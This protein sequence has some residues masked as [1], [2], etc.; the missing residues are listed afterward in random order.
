[1]KVISTPLW[2]W[3]V[4]LGSR[5]FKIVAHDFC[6]LSSSLNASPGCMFRNACG[7]RAL[8]QP[9]VECIRTS[10]WRQTCPVQMACLWQPKSITSPKTNMD[11]PNDG[12]EKVDSFKTWPFLVSMLVFW[13]VYTL[14]KEE[15]KEHENDKS[16][17]RTHKD[18][19]PNSH[20]QS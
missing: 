6:R 10:R 3:I 11:N 13:G 5:P 20:S 7:H 2:T 19:H 17:D 1:M 8:Q 18:C 9:R 15:T 4:S 14:E 12:L 16:N